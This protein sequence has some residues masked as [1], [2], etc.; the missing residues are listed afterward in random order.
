[1]RRIALLLLIVSCRNPTPTTAVLVPVEVNISEID[2]KPTGH[3]FRRSLVIE[4][5]NH[6]ITL[7]MERDH[8]THKV[9]TKFIEFKAEAGHKYQLYEETL[10]DITSRRRKHKEDEE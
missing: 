3:F 9:K 4:P 6:T 1:M 5:G 2:G 8:R 7:H 10:T